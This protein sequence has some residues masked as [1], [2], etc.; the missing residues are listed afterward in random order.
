[1]ANA[2]KWV[3]ELEVVFHRDL[4]LPSIAE[5]ALKNGNATPRETETGSSE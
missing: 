4:L 3:K 2:A 1:M 5:M